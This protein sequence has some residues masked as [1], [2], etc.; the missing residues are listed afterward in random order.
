M[1]EP[2]LWHRA[3]RAEPVPA[4]SPRWLT[5]V[6]APDPRRCRHNKNISAERLEFIYPWW[7]RKFC[8]LNAVLERR[9]QLD[10]TSRITATSQPLR[11]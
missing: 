3:K 4:T 10:H 9:C 5:K 11:R 2:R 1:I 8:H 7:S 6:D